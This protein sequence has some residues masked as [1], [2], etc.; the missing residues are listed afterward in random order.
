MMT[1]QISSTAWLIMVAGWASIIGL[2]AFCFKKMTD[3][4]D[5]TNENPHSRPTNVF[6]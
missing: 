3:D 5:E 6:K 1:D 2:I 4:R